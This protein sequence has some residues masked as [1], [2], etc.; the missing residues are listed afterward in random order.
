MS[1][2]AFV[3]GATGFLGQRLVRLLKREGW[4]VRALVPPS[5]E[6]RLIRG[7]NLEVIRGDITDPASLQ[8]TMADVDALFHL[9]ALVASWHPDAKEFFRVNVGG[10]ENV[11]HEALRSK[12]P[13]FLFTSSLSGIGV[14]PGEIMREDSPPGRVFGDY[15]ASKAEAE[16]RVAA[17]VREHG[18]PAIVLIPSII[19]GPGDVRNTGQFL[20]SFTRGE[21]PGTF[22]ESSAV[23][24]VGVDDVARAHLLAYE[25]G[26][27]GSRYIISAEN[28]TWGDLLRMASLASGTPGPSR[29][30]GPRT[31]WLVSRAS[32][33]RARL[34][35]T[36]PRMPSWL[37][38]F[39][40]TGA[41]MDNTKSIRELGMT[42]KPIGVAIQA[43]VDWFR[44]EGLLPLPRPVAPP[45]SPPDLPLENPDLP[46]PGDIAPE[47][48]E[49]GSP[50][51]RSSKRRPRPPSEPA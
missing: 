41:M 2:S 1:R 21:F 7:A 18:L 46:A 4:R 3:T 33:L 39:M 44:E 25:R 30:I 24:V 48:R 26:T 40:L 50:R 5:E 37:A 14:R 13:R 36:P 28:A 12:V 45:T 31:L 23:P 34:T 32:E 10:T 20:L 9:A 19:I 47:H 29:H 16:R 17:A 38:D 49:A 27:I 6:V 51:D 42:Y 15:E 35:R 22:A 8:G 11:I 43:A